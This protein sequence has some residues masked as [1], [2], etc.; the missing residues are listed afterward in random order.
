MSQDESPADVVA[1]AG[2]RKG[3]SISRLLNLLGFI[4]GPAFAI[5]NGI[6]IL[7]PWE[8]I[9]PEAE[10]NVL[11]F[12]LVTVLVYYGLQ[13][14]L[15]LYNTTGRNITKEHVLLSDIASSASLFIVPVGA[16][17]LGI[18]GAFTPAGLDFLFIS[19]VTVVGITDA[20]GITALIVRGNRRGSE[21]TRE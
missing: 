4:S 17:F 21:V 16:I 9:T 2:P 11:K 6:L 13:I 14:L 1:K 7:G 10:A 12:Y 5:L 3:F 20:L 18:A 19:S 8:F 15:A